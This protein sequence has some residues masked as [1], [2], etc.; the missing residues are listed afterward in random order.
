MEDHCNIY[1]NHNSPAFV[2]RD[3]RA[4]AC[5]LKST[6]ESSN[7]SDSEFQWRLQEHLLIRERLEHVLE[8][9]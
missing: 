5:H 2:Y 1:T 4:A 7:T 6:L 3:L 8:M 9:R